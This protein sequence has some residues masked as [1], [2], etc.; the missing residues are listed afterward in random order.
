[1]SADFW[2]VPDRSEPEFLAAAGCVVG[3]CTASL[4]PSRLA[5]AAL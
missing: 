4:L 3:I 2:I 5:G 1:M